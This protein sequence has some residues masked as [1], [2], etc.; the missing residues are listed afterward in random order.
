MISEVKMVT[1]TVGYIF[2]K[3][4]NL[5]II[6]KYIILD[7]ILIGLKY[8][9]NIKGAIK[10]K[11]KKD[12]KNDFKNQC[13]LILLIKWTLNSIEYS[14]NI[15]IKLFNNGKV[16]FTGCTHKQQIEIALNYLILKLDGLQGPADELFC[17]L[18]SLNDRESIKNFKIIEYLISKTNKT[19]IN[20]TKSKTK[21]EKKSI[22]YLYKNTTDSD[23]YSI[24][25]Y[26]LLIKIYFS[27]F[28]IISNNNTIYEFIDTVLLQDKIIFPIYHNINEKLIYDVSKIDILNINSR[29][30]FNFS[31]NRNNI[32]KLL[33]N[34]PFIENVIY[35]ENIYPGVKAFYKN[36]SVPKL[37]TTSIN[38][39]KKNKLT[40]IFFNSGKINITSTQTQ[41]Q[42]LEI[43]NFL[44]DFCK[45]HYE[46]IC[47]ENNSDVK[48][49]KYIA[50]LQNSIQINNGDLTYVLLK[51]DHIMAN[52]RNQY[53]LN[54][55]NLILN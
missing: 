30:N 17:S 8:N 5:N 23:I 42:T 1:M 36:T 29:L 37:S 34:N 9:N 4:I 27:D 40:I 33:K 21:R 52:K 39:K 16:I 28:D 12:L 19:I 44:V 2:D 54:K 47:I 51:K 20:D 45:K 7:D 48:L 50:S 15:N 6:Y 25:N 22:N 13:T 38:L 31:L 26:F 32:Y 18:K 3:Y 53:I 55:F 11:C 14:K 43:Y 41:E 10:K 49:K 46:E 35:D 24:Y